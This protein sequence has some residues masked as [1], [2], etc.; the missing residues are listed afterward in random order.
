MN[1]EIIIFFTSARWVKSMTNTRVSNIWR[2]IEIIKKTDSIP[3]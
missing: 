1:V 3:F 2:L